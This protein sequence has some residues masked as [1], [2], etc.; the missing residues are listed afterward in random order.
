LAI[1]RGNVVRRPAAVD[2]KIVPCDPTVKGNSATSRM[3]PVTLETGLIVHVPQYLKEYE[4]IRVDA[5]SGAF[6]ARA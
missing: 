5:R 4:T 1:S 3:K 2:L 6:L